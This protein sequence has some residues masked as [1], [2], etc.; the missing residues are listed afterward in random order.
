M[1]ITGKPKLPLGGFPPAKTVFSHDTE[2]HPWS[3]EE[4]LRSQAKERQIQGFAV[5]FFR[6]LKTLKGKKGFTRSIY[7]KKVLDKIKLIYFQ[8][9]PLLRNY[10]FA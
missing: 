7:I 2:S 6:Q 8:L 10:F 5:N 3:Y 9:A 1:G 4:C